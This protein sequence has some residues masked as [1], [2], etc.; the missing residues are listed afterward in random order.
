[1]KG[2]DSSVFPVP[3]AVSNENFPQPDSGPQG[4]GATDV[5]RS[6]QAGERTPRPF[7]PVFVSRDETRKPLVCPGWTRGPI[8][9]TEGSGAI[10]AAE[11]TGTAPRTSSVPS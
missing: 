7:T 2:H 9:R 3:V 11:A 5:P 8:I 10:A 1:M 4:S 6:G